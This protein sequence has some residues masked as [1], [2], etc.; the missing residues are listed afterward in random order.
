MKITIKNRKSQSLFINLLFF[1][2]VFIVFGYNFNTVDDFIYSK[3]VA[4]NYLSVYS[5]QWI[6]YLCYGIN[7]IFPNVNGWGLLLVCMTYISSYKFFHFLLEKEKTTANIILY[8]VY[9]LTVFW[10]LYQMQYT[11]ISSFALSVGTF[12]IN[13][14]IRSKNKE[15][16]IIGI[17]LFIFGFCIRKEGLVFV[18]PLICLLMFDNIQTRNKRDIIKQIVIFGILASILITSSVIDINT[19]P[20]E[21][22]NYI[23]FNNLRHEI[24]DKR[25][26]NLPVMRQMGSVS[27]NDY[28]TLGNW[29]Y[30]D[31]DYMTE[32]RFATIISDL[33]K[34]IDKQQIGVY[35]NAISR[36]FHSLFVSSFFWIIMFL[37][38]GFETKKK[39]NLIILIVSLGFIGIYILINRITYRTL[40]GSFLPLILYLLLNIKTIKV[41]K[42]VHFI[43]MSLLLVITCLSYSSYNYSEFENKE[44]INSYDYELLE[45]QENIYYITLH[46]SIIEEGKIPILS[47]KTKFVFENEILNA[48]VQRHPIETTTLNSFSIKNPIKELPYNDNFYLITGKNEDECYLISKW[49][50]EHYNTNIVCNIEKETDSYVVWKLIEKGENHE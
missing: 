28:E 32:E 9:F 11:I 20:K 21:Y 33:D 31:Y 45:N 25:I 48:W 34:E 6:S 41:N 49:H 16:L 7:K 4:N 27:I 15:N 47:K 44:F 50:K 5:F 30:N 29:I 23:E 10:L 39:E 46:A 3:L 17:I 13:A 24:A 42:I 18:L 14:F 35:F 38:C 2:F 40:F 8:C 1:V 22:K 19:Y 43:F 37:L 36:T 12:C 26:E